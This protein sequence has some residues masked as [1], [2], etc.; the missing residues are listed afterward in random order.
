MNP[1][2]PELGPLV[3]E[4]VGSGITVPRHRGIDEKFATHQ[5][6]F[7]GSLV[8]LLA[9]SV[10]LVAVLYVTKKW[11]GLDAGDVRDYGALIVGPLMTLVA[12]VIGFYFGERRRG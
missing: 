1:H 4:D 12:S 7:G 8:V 3:V 6:F 5:A 11:T 10:L 9:I 2:D